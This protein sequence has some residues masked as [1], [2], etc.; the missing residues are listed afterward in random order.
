MLFHHSCLN[1]V[2]ILAFAIFVSTSSSIDAFSQETIG[3]LSML[4]PEELE[5]RYEISVSSRETT[6]FRCKVDV[7][8]DGSVVSIHLQLIK[9]EATARGLKTQ[10]KNWSDAINSNIGGAIVDVKLGSPK[11]TDL[12]TLA[13]FKTLKIGLVEV[14]LTIA[15]EFASK[16]SPYWTI[17]FV[18]NDN[19]SVTLASSSKSQS[20]AWSNALAILPFAISR[21]E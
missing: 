19:Q 5:R 15:K 13:A 7:C 8:A 16:I 17:G 2:C 21:F 4:P 9:M 1:R 6:F 18:T 20:F 14:E 11:V 3:G 12:G 10:V